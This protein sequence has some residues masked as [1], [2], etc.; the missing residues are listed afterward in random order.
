MFNN[1][2][3]KEQAKKALQEARGIINQMKQSGH[4]NTAMTNQSNSN[5]EISQELGL[6]TAQLRGNNKQSQNQYSTIRPA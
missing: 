5:M 6:D 3:Q 4:S 2:Q 1:Q